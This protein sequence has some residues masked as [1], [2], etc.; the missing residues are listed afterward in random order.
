VAHL[1]AQYRQVHTARQS[2]SVPSFHTDAC[3]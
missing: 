2:S 3:H 1:F